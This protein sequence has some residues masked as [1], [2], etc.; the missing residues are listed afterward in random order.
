MKDLY[1]FDF[2][3][4]AVGNVVCVISLCVLT[5]SQSIVLRE[6]EH[7]CIC[8]CLGVCVYVRL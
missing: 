5:V 6:G 7:V 1:V 2:A 8:E 4:T 3:V